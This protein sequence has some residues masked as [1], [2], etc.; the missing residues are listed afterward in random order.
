LF[1]VVVTNYSAHTEWVGKGGELV[2]PIVLE[3]EPLTNIRRAIID[4]D[5]YVASLLSLIDN[6]ELRKK[7]GEAGREIAREMDWEIICKQW[8]GLIDSVLY[9]DGNIPEVG[10]SEDLKYKLEAF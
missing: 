5:K 8:E 3:S 7:Y 9:P 4:V 6:K 2:D 10:R 1:P